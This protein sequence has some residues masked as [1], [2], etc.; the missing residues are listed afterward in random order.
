[1]TTQMQVPKELNSVGIVINSGGRQR[2]CSAYPVAD[3]EVTLPSTL[4]LEPADSPSDPVTLSV[5]GFTQPQPDFETT[6]VAAVPDVGDN[7][8][9]VL[10]RRRTPY[11]QDRILY[12][13]MPLRHACTDK[14]CPDGETCIGGECKSQDIDPNVLPD[15]NDSLVYGNTNTCFSL[16]NCMPPYAAIPAQLVDAA[17]CR[18]RV[19]VPDGAG[20]PINGLNVRILHENFTPEILDLDPEEGFVVDDPARPTEFRLASSLCNSRYKKGKVLG[21]W[22][23]TLCP[24][25]T[26]F[27]PLCADDAR[28]LMAGEYSPYGEATCV[29]GDRLHPTESALYVVMDRSASMHEFFGPEGLQEVLGLS[30]QDPVF[31]RTYVG[32]KFMPASPSD[33]SATESSPNSFAS[34]TGPKDVPFVLAVDAR[35]AVAGLIGDTSNVL[36]DDPP[37]LLDAVMSPGGAYAALS[38]LQPTAPSTAFNR[39]ALLILGNRDLW[40]RCGGA[41]PADLAAQALADEIHTYVVALKAP[42]GTDQGGR[43]PVADAEAIALAGGTQLF[44]ATTDP[45]AGALALATIVTDLGS[46]VYDQPDGVSLSTQPSSFTLSY[47]DP[48]TQIKVVVN[49]DPACSALSTD[50]SG[51]NLDSQGRV[52]ICGSACEALRNT[53]KASALFAAQQSLPPPLIPIHVNAPCSQ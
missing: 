50:A 45:N 3:G 34:L 30:L 43:N 8:V 6:C 12:L 11:I 22:G 40:T 15:Y 39:R 52:R 29:Q 21:V 16:S 48:V 18:F 33:C 41:S 44:D 36:S 14:R 26:P 51:W 49:H 7:S 53:I 31:E 23:S 42:A 37:L 9:T 25:K 32:F 1:M 28:Q 2:F 13:P 5:L 27:Q 17:D 35:Q 10:R 24:A 20:V 19:D 47:F 46:C 38:S 4:G